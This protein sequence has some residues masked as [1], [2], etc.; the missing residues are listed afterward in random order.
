[1]N[2]PFNRP[3]IFCSKGTYEEVAPEEGYED[4]GISALV[5]SKFGSGKLDLID[6]VVFRCNTCGNIQSFVTEQVNT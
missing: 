1:M 5:I 4:N 2:V 6:S 3:C